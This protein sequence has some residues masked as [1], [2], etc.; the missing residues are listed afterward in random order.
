MR[1]HSV[2][3]PTPEAQFAVDAVREAG[4]LA[5]RIQQEL[6]VEALAKDDRSPVTVADF[7]AQ[8]VVAYRLRERFPDAVLVGEESAAA[9]RS[10]DGQQFL[11]VITRFVRTV[12]PDATDDDVLGWI[13]RGAG[14]PPATFWTLDP[15]DGTKGFLRG[16]QYAVAF[17][18]IE[19]GRVEV[20]A[21]GCPE[22][23]DS[24]TADGT[25]P[26]TV[27]VAQRGHGAWHSSL[28]VVGQ[29]QRL[30]VSTTTNIADARLLRSVE[31]AH[32]NTGT[33]GELV[34]ALGIN[35][36]PVPLDSQAK[37]AV[38]AAGA[39]EALLRLISSSRPDYRERIWD[40]AA[41]SIVVEEA[42]GRV[43]DL[44]GKPLDFSRGRGL[45]RNRGVLATNGHLHDALLAGLRS[46]GA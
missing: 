17:A 2:M 5:K 22:L 24:R 43:S 42:G 36:P 3:I 16:D 45:E 37:Y 21:L 20:G 40:Q 29:W 25:G 23:V 18:R 33:M 15:V 4:L 34:A 13:D 35:A 9:L 38:L 7:A 39:G 41:G 27:A 8:A 31:S 14:D 32:T 19:N 12:I 11:P 26:G 28:A 1:Q 30:T 44:D 10:G 6:V 46:V